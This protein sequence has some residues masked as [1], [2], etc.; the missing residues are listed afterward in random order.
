MGL[1]C[2]CGSWGK[3]FLPLI[4]GGSKGSSLEH[5][6][7]KAG[8]SLGVISSLITCSLLASYLMSFSLTMLIYKLNMDFYEDYII[9]FTTLRKMSGI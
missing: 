7:L 5:E 4:H 9:I 1:F 2:L 3:Q 8:D 6:P